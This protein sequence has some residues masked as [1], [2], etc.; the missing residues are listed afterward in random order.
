MVDSVVN[1]VMETNGGPVK[2]PIIGFS[3]TDVLAISQAI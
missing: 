3:I 2:K 1:I